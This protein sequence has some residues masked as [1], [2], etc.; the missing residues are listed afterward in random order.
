MDFDVNNDDDDND[1]N[2]DDDNDDDDDDD[3][4][5]DDDDDEDDDDNEDDDDDEDDAGWPK[6]R[7]DLSN[8]LSIP[9]PPPSSCLLS[10]KSHSH[11]TIRGNKLRRPNI[12]FL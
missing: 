7:N 1:D 6:V 2:D 10:G 11:A 9:F 4:D 5:K 12:T 3:D 8:T